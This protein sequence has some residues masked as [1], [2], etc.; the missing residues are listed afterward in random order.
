MGLARS[1]FYDAPAYAT[2]DTDIVKVMAMICDGP[3][4]YGWRRV[5][6]VLRQN[7]LQVNHT[8]VRRLM[9]EHDLQQKVRRRVTT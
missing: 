1:S 9:R 2:D 6:A 8:K 5:Q 7:D 4:H 3:E